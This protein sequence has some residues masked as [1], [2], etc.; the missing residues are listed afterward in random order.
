M[1]GREQEVNDNSLLGFIWVL[2][3]VISYHFPFLIFHYSDTLIY[4][5]TKTQQR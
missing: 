2:R 4:L 1:N 3:I 5:C